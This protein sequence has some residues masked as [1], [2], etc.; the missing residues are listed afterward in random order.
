LASET[1]RILKPGGEF[2]FV[3][4]SKPSNKI[5]HFFYSLYLGRIIPVLGKLFL[6]NPEDYKMLWTYTHTFENAKKAREIFANTGLKTTFNSYFYGCATGF[7]GQKIN[8]S[9]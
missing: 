4:V 2:S 3:E 5:L 7:S 9:K 6:G 8:T 1:K